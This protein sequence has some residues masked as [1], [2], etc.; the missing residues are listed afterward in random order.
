MVFYLL[1]G[2]PHLPYLAVS[3]HTLRR[4]GYDGT[5]RVYA[6][7]ESFEIVSRIAQDGRLDAEACYDSPPYR[8][9]NDQF[10]RKIQLAQQLT[11]PALYLDADTMVC[12]DPTPILE[13]LDPATFVATQFNDWTTQFTMVQGRLNDLRDVPEIPAPLIDETLNP[14]HLSLNGGVWACRPDS[15]VLPLWYAWSWAARGKFIADE[16]VLHLVQTRFPG[17]V[18]IMAGGEWNASPKFSRLPN[19]EVCL[20]H[21]HGDSNVRPNK[22][23]K[24]LALWWPVYQECLAANVGG[25]AEWKAETPNRWIQEL[26]NKMPI[27][28]GLREA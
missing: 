28:T 23:A 4:A 10:L 16:K 20:W 21:F 13:A 26:E 19:D 18:A 5:I 12:A 27:V 9:K 22:T 25:I 14:G 7:A 17:E 6:W 15:P 1:S 11:S 2:R 24:G 8:G 3:L